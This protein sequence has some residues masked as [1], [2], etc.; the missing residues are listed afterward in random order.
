MLWFGFPTHSLLRGNKWAPLL[1]LMIWTMQ[2]FLSPIRLISEQQE[3]EGPLWLRTKWC[4]SPSV[5]HIPSSHAVIGTRTTVDHR[6]CTEY[7]NMYRL[8]HVIQWTPLSTVLRM[9]VIFWPDC[10]DKVVSC[11]HLCKWPLHHNNNEHHHTAWTESCRATRHA[12]SSWG[13]IECGWG[14]QDTGSGS[15]HQQPGRFLPLPYDWKGLI[16][17][18][19]PYWSAAWT[20]LEP[21]ET[22]PACH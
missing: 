4:L 14:P 9:V 16:R 10:L 3:E 21:T 7:T 11:H 8:L 18:R 2:H 22:K 17:A 6:G 12:L 20:A 13:S 5:A 1:P 19:G 15:S